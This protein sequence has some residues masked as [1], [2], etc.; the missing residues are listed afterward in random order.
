M[1]EGERRWN[2]QPKVLRELWLPVRNALL[3]RLNT[4]GVGNTD[5]NCLV[6]LK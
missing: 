6:K 5:I 2:V 4:Q 3:Q 1:E